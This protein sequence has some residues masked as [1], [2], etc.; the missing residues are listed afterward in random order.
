[1]SG[2]GAAAVE[3]YNT[4]CEADE[5]QWQFRRPGTS[6]WEPFAEAEHK[7]IETAHILKE[8]RVQI[9]MGPGFA[10][11][12][13]VDLRARNFSRGYGSMVMFDVRRIVLKTVG[14]IM[15]RKHKKLVEAFKQDK[16]AKK[17]GDEL[18]DN[19]KNEPDED[20]EEPADVI[21]EKLVEFCQ[22][23][24]VDETSVQP[25]IMFWQMSV[26]GCVDLG[27]AGA[28]GALCL[29]ADAPTSY[30]VLLLVCVV[31]QLRPCRAFL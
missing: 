20:D 7:T 16:K 2:G 22:A 14:E 21:E 12:T 11:R 24:G 6:K 19:F 3:D 27:A 28:F 29:L 31:A 13:V 4:A 15:T 23:I 30:M 17:F 1:M 5:C 25:A 8:A 18:F 9:S 10:G 26:G